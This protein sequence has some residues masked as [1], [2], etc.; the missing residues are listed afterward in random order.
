MGDVNDLIE[1]LKKL[2]PTDQQQVAAACS[3][4]TDSKSGNTAGASLPANDSWRYNNPARVS[5]FSGDCSKSEVSFEQWRFEVRGLI[6]DKIYPEPVIL[7][8]LRRSLRGSAADVFLHMGDEASLNDVVSKLERI[9]GNILSQEAVLEQFY[10]AKQLESE[11]VAAW[12]CRIEDLRS[13]LQG[14]TGDPKS[15]SLISVDAAK[16]MTRTKFCS[17]SRPGNVKNAIRHTFDAKASYEDLLVA[18]RV[19]EQEDGIEKK[20]Y[21]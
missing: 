20:N 15:T 18:A 5:T 1:Q 3:V 19:A 6:R 17:G 4:D 16:T 13:K 21:S 8:T 11:S 7:Q 2:S 12:S 10:S 9:F 14:K